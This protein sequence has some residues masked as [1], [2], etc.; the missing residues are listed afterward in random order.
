M[1]FLLLAALHFGT[2]VLPV[3][4]STT[5]WNNCTSCY[6]QHCT[7]EQLYF[8]LLAALHFETTVLPV[9]CS[10]ALF[11]LNTGLYFV[12]VFEKLSEVVVTQSDTHKT[13]TEL[14]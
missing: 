13:T 8:L 9:T 7:L 3:T 10:T 4:C 1:Y 6:L 14:K 12:N 11:P 2:T 5:L